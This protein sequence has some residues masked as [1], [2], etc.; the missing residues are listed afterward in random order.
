MSGPARTGPTR[1]AGSDRPL[2][3]RALA[4]WR[5]RIV[6]EQALPLR[7]LR[8]FARI[9]GRNRA[10]GLAGQAFIT[11]VPLLILTASA[12]GR[13]VGERLVARFR[14]S[15]EGA[16]AMRDL[17]ARPPSATGAMSAVG[18]VIMIASLLSLTRLLQRLYEAAW[19]LPPRGLP[20][21]VNGLAGLALLIAQLVVL[22]LLASALRGV[23][24]GGLIR[25]T[26]QLALAL[27]LWLL[28]QHLLLS[29]RVPAR[30]LL[31]GAAVAAI[32]QLAVGIGSGLW[33]PRLVT[34]NAD[35]YGLVGVAFALISWL[36]VVA[37]MVVAGAVIGAEVARGPVEH[38]SPA[39]DDSPTHPPDLP[40]GHRRV[41]AA[42]TSGASEGTKMTELVV[43]GF[44]DKER[45]E[46]VMDLAERLGRQELLD[47]ED[48]A[49]VWRTPEGKIKIQQSMSPAAAGALSGALWG[50]LLGLLFLVPFFGMAVGAATGAA[51]G[52]LADIGIDDRFIK[53]VAATIT[54]GS[55]AIFALVRRSTPDRVRAELAP[56]EPTVLRTSLT[57]EREEELIA[58][59]QGAGTATGEKA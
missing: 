33:M 19:E 59:L 47:L 20:G 40:Y 31:P 54:P 39:G 35:R 10:L 4:G 1:S 48:A 36:V 14:L 53:E 15:G 46:Q 43:L 38:R 37:V 18:I 11:L 29:R 44:P 45:A 58:A 57:K 27:P 16:A 56:Y 5:Q 22:A 28:L 32:G 24:A 52:K 49:L 26:A 17:F 9:D 3:G 30:A 42:D 21:T 34:N 12:T 2:A 7:C 50:M 13:G 23:P 25:H 6:R 41:S 8:R 55:A 51:A